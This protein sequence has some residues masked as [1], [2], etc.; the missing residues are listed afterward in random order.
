MMKDTHILADP[1]TRP[2]VLIV[3]DRADNLFAYK[4][5]LKKLDCDTAIVSSGADALHKLEKQDFALILL[6]TDMPGMDGF[7]TL[8]KIKTNSQF[9]H[10]PV[11][12]VA[13]SD[14][15]PQ[16]N[17]LAYEMGAIDLLIRPF[18]DT[19]LRAKV[20]ALTQVF[21]QHRKTVLNL[22]QLTMAENQSSIEKQNSLLKL[23]SHLEEMPHA[24]LTINTEWKLTYFNRSAA[25]LLGPDPSHF[26]DKDIWQMIPSLEVLAPLW[27]QALEEQNMQTGEVLIPPSEKFA[28]ERWL[29]TWAYPV[30]DGMAISLI[31]ITQKKNQM[32]LQEQC[33]SQLNTAKDDAEAKVALKTAFLNKVSQDIRF[34]LQSLLESADRLKDHSAK[35][36][37]PLN[38]ITALHHHGESL[39]R[40]IDDVVE[41]SESESDKLSITVDL[42]DPQSIVNDVSSLL[43]LKAREKSLQF[44]VTCDKSTAGLIKTD[45]ARLREIIMN[46]A[47]N[48]IKYTH[49]GIIKI[50]IFPLI[51]DGKEFTAFDITDTGVGINP[52]EQDQ[53]FDPQQ[54]LSLYVARRFARALGGDV[55]LVSSQMGR[56]STFLITVANRVEGSRS[57]PIISQKVPTEIHRPLIPES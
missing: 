33:I 16:M 37:N 54:G 26:F 27:K 31:D 6:D 39:F 7:S 4:A 55:H 46:V 17:Q 47:D 11:I 36:D 18:N 52:L 12:L 21:R 14:L 9:Q 2:H 13:D 43:K 51:A 5:A 24:F 15:T 34:P 22:Q 28:T 20:S 45:A 56:G 10:I 57:Q 1:S 32:I 8:Q 44:Q 53:L 48:A 25:E 42:I 49:Q 35:L 41:L 40:Y 3:D 30:A 38:A 50:H 23:V 19:L 29:E